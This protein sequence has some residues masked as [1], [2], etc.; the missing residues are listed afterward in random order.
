MTERPILFSAPMV[1]AILDG[2][3]TVTRRAVKPQ[4]EDGATLAF[5]IQKP[6]AKGSCAHFAH[7]DERGIHSKELTLHCP[8]GMPGDRLWVR[9]A[10]RTTGD[11]GRCDRMPPREIQPHAVWYEADPLPFA[12]PSNAPLPGKLRPSMFMPR[13]ASRIA[14]EITDVRVERL[15]SISEPDAMAEGVEQRG[16]SWRNYLM[17]DAPEAGFNCA[18]NSFRSLWQSI[19]GA[20]SWDVNPWVW[21]ISFK[22][23]TP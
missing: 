4:P 10:W 20:E 15:Q 12:N 19:N 9:E 7:V 6:N 18:Y 3:K 17:P 23:V 8:H 21:A 22:R 11:D 1:R 2:R 5:L 13:W 16:E 14:L